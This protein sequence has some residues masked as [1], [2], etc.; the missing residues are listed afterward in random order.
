[1]NNAIVTQ[2]NKGD[3]MSLLYDYLTGPE[4]RMQIEAIKDAFTEMET[5]L[6]KEQR[7]AHSRWKRRQKQI[8]KV[9][10][11]TVGMYG[12]LR[13]IAGST[14]PMIEELEDYDENPIEE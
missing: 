12:S 1:M 8:E 6:H 5:D 7:A 11:N 14:V 2:A 4:F 9:M 10:V 13:G 3:K